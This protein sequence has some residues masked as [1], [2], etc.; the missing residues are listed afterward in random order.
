MSSPAYPLL[1]KARAILFHK[2]NSLPTATVDSVTGWAMSDGRPMLNFT[3][4]VHACTGSCLAAAYC[5]NG[6]AS[7]A[8]D[9]RNAITDLY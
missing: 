6:P 5:D 4:P 7:L 9:D 1:V 2:F 3:D 8:T